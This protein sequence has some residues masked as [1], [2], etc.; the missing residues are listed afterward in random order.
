MKTTMF[1]LLVAIF[2]IVPVLTMAQETETRKPGSFSKVNLRGFFDVELV[3]GGEEGIQIKAKNFPLDKLVTRI[4]NDILIIEKVKSYRTRLGAKVKLYITYKNLEGIKN[5][6]SGDVLCKSDVTGNATK[7]QSSGSGNLR[8]E[9]TI[10]SDEVNVKNSGSGDI[11]LSRVEGGSL[12]MEK[13][14]SGNFTVD[15]GNV[16]NQ[17]LRSSGSGNIM[18]GGLISQNCKIKISGS[19]NARIHAEEELYARVSGSGNINY[20]GN[21]RIDSKVSGSGKVRNY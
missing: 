19:G 12:Y 14:G 17:E 6:G 2:C 18:A 3:K 20:K 1:K 11:Y 5:S 15:A 10:K 13:S 4:E 21:A 8:V 9:G 16:K 7:F